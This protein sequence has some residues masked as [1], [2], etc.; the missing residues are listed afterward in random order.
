MIWFIVNDAGLHLRCRYPDTPDAR[1]SMDTWLDGV[2]TALREA[3][4]VPVS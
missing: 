1:E 2:S 4:P 3:A